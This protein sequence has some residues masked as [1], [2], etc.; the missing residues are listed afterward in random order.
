MASLERIADHRPNPL[1]EIIL[2]ETEG[3]RRIGNQTP[4]GQIVEFLRDQVNFGRLRHA[5][6]RRICGYLIHGQT[7]KELAEEEKVTETQIRSHLKSSLKKIGIDLDDPKQKETIADIHES[8][9]RRRTEG[10]IR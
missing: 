10:K 4:R 8:A 3:R 6:S 2:K 9:R 5:A 1:D 7:I